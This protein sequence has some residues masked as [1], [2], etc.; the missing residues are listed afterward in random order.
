[1]IA[2]CLKCREVAVERG[3]GVVETQDVYDAEAQY[4]Q[5][6]YDEL[7]DEMHKQVPA[8]RDYFQALRNMGKNRFT[9]AEWIE[10]L[11]RREDQI[12]EDEARTRLK[13]LFDYSV[14]GVPRR[15][16]SEGGT[17][18]QF[19]YNTRLLEP[20]FDAEMTVHPALK[21]ELQLKE[22]RKDSAEAEE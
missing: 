15:G 5:H 4:S 18:F 13:V 10:V 1:M 3:H 14:V 9:L 2:F 11:R 21:K 7:D 12:T 6:I 22:V 16:G 8:I 19:K 20:D 17:K